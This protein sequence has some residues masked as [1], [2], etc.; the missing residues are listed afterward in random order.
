MRRQCGIVLQ[1]SKIMAASIFENIA[2]GAAITLDA[3]W[4]TAQAAGLAEE[5]AAMSMGMHTVVS[6]GESNLYG[7]L[8][9]S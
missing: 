1:H 6:E 3:A 7:M 5:I 9:P 2:A 4:E 8:C